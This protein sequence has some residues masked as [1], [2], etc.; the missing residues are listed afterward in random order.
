M[1]I[2]DDFRLNLDGV[3]AP[4]PG[5]EPVI[6]VECLCVMQGTSSVTALS[7]ET[8][9][10]LGTG[11]LVQYESTIRLKADANGCAKHADS[12]DPSFN[13]ALTGEVRASYTNSWYDPA[14]TGFKHRIIAEK[15]EP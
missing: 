9:G 11:A 15:V 12:C 7:D 5:A 1:L 13:D 14:E 2:D 10:R 4:A 3:S 6:P 8:P